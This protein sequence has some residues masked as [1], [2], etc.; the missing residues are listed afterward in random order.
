MAGE[1]KSK[2]SF[3][4]ESIERAWIKQ[5]LLNQSKMLVRNRTKEIAGGE[6]WTLRG[7][8]IEIVNAIAARF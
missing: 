4:F 5:A 2:M 8:E 1:L 3:E 6:V 7:K